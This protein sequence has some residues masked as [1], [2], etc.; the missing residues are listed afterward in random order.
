MC[1]VL[2]FGNPDTENGGVEFG[3][4]GE[5]H[6]HE[7]TTEGGDPSTGRF[8]G[9]ACGTPLESGGRANDGVGESS[10]AILA[11]LGWKRDTRDSIFTPTRG[12]LHD[13]ALEG[14]LPYGE[15]RYYKLTYNQQ[16]FYPISKDYTLAL[17]ADLGYAESLGGR[18][19]P[20]FEN[21]YAGGIGSVRGFRSSSLGPG[22]DPVDNVALGGQ[23]R[24][25]GSAELILPVAGT[26]NDRTFRWFMFLDGG[27]VFPAGQFDASE[28]RYSTGLG[29]TWLSPIGPMKFS[30]G[31]PLNSKPEDREQR[32]QFQIGTGF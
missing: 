24:V 31:Y 7:R 16:Y 14:T 2:T 28:F 26:G 15:L 8:S 13:A 19:F 32:L 9:Y 6:S 18:Q 20:P 3:L 17:N 5:N 27:N 21:F 23:T 22:R 12:R 1:M 10:T 25:V 30:L 4:A 11:K 29:L